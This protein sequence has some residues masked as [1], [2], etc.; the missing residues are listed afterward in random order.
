MDS[1]CIWDFWDKS[2]AITSAGD[3][4]VAVTVFNLNYLHLQKAI[5]YAQVNLFPNL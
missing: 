3:D 5:G 4:I 1:L 2:I